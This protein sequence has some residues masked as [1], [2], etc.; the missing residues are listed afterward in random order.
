MTL[1]RVL[2]RRGFLGGLLALSACSSGPVPRDTFFRLGAPATPAALPG[3]PIKGIVE[4]PPFH[5]TGVINERALLYRESARGLAQYNYQTWLE[6]PSLMVQRTFIEALRG[7][8]AFDAVASP[9]MRQD[10]DYELLGDLREWEHVLP[11]A[12]GP[13]AAI[14][15]DIGLRRIAGNRAVLVKSY[16]I[17]EPAADGSVD[18]AVQ[19]FT[20]GLDKIIAQVLTDLATLP[21]APSA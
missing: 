2:A 20:A 17:Q 5:A 11:S 10:R 14:A 12:G 6:P 8:R 7:A 15:I 9:E 18:A 13:A 16:E 4:V 3:G 19:A 1:S 21:K